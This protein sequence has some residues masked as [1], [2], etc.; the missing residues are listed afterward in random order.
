MIV[1]MAR[2]NLHHYWRIPSPSISDCDSGLFSR[3]STPGL[4]PP[5]ISPPQVLSVIKNIQPARILQVNTSLLLSCLTEAGKPSRFSS[6][7]NLSTKFEK[8]VV[9]RGSLPDICE[10]RGRS[11]SSLSWWWDN[12]FSGSDNEGARMVALSQHGHTITRFCHQN[13]NNQVTVNGQHICKF[14]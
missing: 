10:G 8:T 6:L 14:S 1:T 4:S 11:D 5:L 3:S 12:E 9:A 7:G 2:N 13:C